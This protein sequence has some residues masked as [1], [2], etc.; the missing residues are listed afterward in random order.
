MAF[1]PNWVEFDHAFY[2]PICKDSPPPEG[3][4]IQAENP[5]QALAF[6]KLLGPC[7]SV[8]QNICLPGSIVYVA[9]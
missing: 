3:L 1:D 6:A 2:T 9:P 8:E 5:G 4:L 7:D